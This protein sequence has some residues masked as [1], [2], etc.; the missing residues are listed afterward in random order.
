MLPQPRRK[1]LL[2]EWYTYYKH[3]CPLYFVY[4]NE[5]SSGLNVPL[6][7]TE[8]HA[9]RRLKLACS[10][11]PAKP[12]TVGQGLLNLYP[13]KVYWISCQP[14]VIEYHASR[15]LLSMHPVRGYWMPTQLRLLNRH[16]AK[17]YWIPTHVRVIECILGQGLLYAHQLRLLN[18]DPGKG[19]WIAFQSKVIERG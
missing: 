13:H 12:P 11:S 18:P 2:D 8:Q 15:G 6:I 10:P 9:A 5:I 7:H 14:R 19:S 1:A 16:P 3:L 17:G 4:H